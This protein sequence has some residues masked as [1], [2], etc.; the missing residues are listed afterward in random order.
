MGV[1]NQQIIPT[2]S[3]KNDKHIQFDNRVEVVLI[4]DIQDYKQA[5]LHSKLW[6]QNNEIETFRAGVIRS[7]HATAAATRTNHSKLVTQPGVSTTLNVRSARSNIQNNVLNQV[8]IPVMN[9][10]FTTDYGLDYGV[11]VDV[12]D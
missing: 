2:V 3:I 12:F 1:K 10:L 6:W 4:P 7:I 8:K 9:S 5:G 11:F